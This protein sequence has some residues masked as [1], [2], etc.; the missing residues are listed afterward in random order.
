M[1][2]TQKQKT[3]TGNHW[4]PMTFIILGLLINILIAFGVSRIEGPTL[5]AGRENQKQILDNYINCVNLGHCPASEQMEKEIENFFKLST[6]STT[7]AT[8]KSPQTTTKDVC[9]PSKNTLVNNLLAKYWADLGCEKMY[10]IWRIAQAESA[11]KARIHNRGLNKNGTIDFGWCGVNTIHRDKGESIA[12]FEK[13]MYNL[14][15]NI[16][17]CREIYNDR[18]SWDKD[19]FK[20]WS[21]FNNL[22]Y[23]TFK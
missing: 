22:K 21:T 3:K 6:A 23:L 20:A 19:G 14:E 4:K 12:A 13:R 18:A 9:R 17:K 2:L 8:E 1:K 15:E 7:V 10:T 16:K 11:G 5:T